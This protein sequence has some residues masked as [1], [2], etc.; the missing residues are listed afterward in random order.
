MCSLPSPGHPKQQTAPFRALYTFKAHRGHENALC[1]LL[2]EAGHRLCEDPGI[3][4]L[5]LARSVNR[6]DGFMVFSR[7]EDQASLTRCLAKHRIR[8]LTRR[9]ASH[10]AHYSFDLL[11]ADDPPG[12]PGPALHGAGGVFASQLALPLRAHVKTAKALMDMHSRRAQVAPGCL[13]VRASVHSK[14]DDF[15]HLWTSWESR[16]AFDL[17]MKDFPIAGKWHH[18]GEKGGVAALDVL[19]PILNV[20]ATRLG[21]SLSQASLT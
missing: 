4:G 18:P 10:S 14:R 6:G 15:F 17:E 19:E 20:V 9:I 21:S 5:T 8:T 16:A 7:W 1:D 3:R 11:A 2:V 12:T 13:M